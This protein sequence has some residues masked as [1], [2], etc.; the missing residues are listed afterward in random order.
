MKHSL[1]TR[2]GQSRTHLA[3]PFHSAITR[4]I[5]SWLKPRDTHTH[6]RVPRARFGVR[7]KTYLLHQ[8]IMSDIAHWV[9][10]G[11]SKQTG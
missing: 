7:I 1:N 10:I 8:N 5:R 2:I 11:Y 3:D 9:D 6:T 4:F